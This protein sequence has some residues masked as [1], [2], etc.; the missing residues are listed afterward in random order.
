MSRFSFSVY[1]FLVSV[2]M[3][4]TVALVEQSALAQGTEPAKIVTSDGV[5]LHAVFYPSEKRNAP[6]VIMLHPIGEGKSSKAPE[7]KNLAE[8]LQKANYSVIMFDF[9]GHG[10]STTIED[11][12]LFWKKLAN[13]NNV[14]TKDKDAIEVKDYIKQGSTY[15]PVLV[16]DIAAVRG[17]L[18]RRNDDSK[19][20]NTSSLIVIGAD[21][22][23]TLGAL[24]INSEWYRHKYAPPMPVAVVIP[25][26]VETRPEGK[27]IIAAVFLTPHASL[28]KRTV[29]VTSLLRIA[30]KDNA[31][32]AAF[33][34]G[35]DDTKSRD[36]A[37]TLEKGLRTKTS[38]KHDYIGAVKLNTK[39]SGVKLL[40]P[41]LKTD[42]YIVKY[43]DSV[44][45]DR[46]NDRTDRDF[47]ATSYVWRLPGNP[48]QFAPAKKKGDKN[49]SFD[50][51]NKFIPQ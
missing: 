30:S 15:L 38:K 22:G 4:A 35:E 32:A 7:W 11:R 41:S 44:M 25:K 16:N 45:E 39:L 27:D 47:A 6:T 24:W 3:F 12:D 48:Q 51:Y 8:S 9:R 14:R 2:A 34:Y 28:E 21:S 20:C 40:Q 42:E 19:D 13:T 23:A 37:V 43:L 36:Y 49:L 33:F 50:E 1:L 26:F 18:E 46:K 31:M 5:K 29:S 17:W 10:D